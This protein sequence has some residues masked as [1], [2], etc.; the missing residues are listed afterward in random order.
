MCAAQGAAS[1]AS[2]PPE[3]AADGAAAAHF[4]AG[5]S[6]SEGSA[7]QWSS[8]EGELEGELEARGSARGAAAAGQGR[9]GARAGSSASSEPGSRGGGAGS[10]ASTY[11]RPERTDRKE[12]LSAI[13]EQCA[14]PPAWGHHVHT[15]K[16]QRRS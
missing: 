5:D 13:D 10:I 1:A 7:E 4:D 12:A 16:A 3:H 14:A 6:D 8:D 11:W 2:P 9:D 15:T